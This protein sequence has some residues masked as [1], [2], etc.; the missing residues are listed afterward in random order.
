MKRERVP[1]RTRE[2]HA[3]TQN[4]LSK[5]GF[6]PLTFWLRGDS[7]NHYATV[8]NWLFHVKTWGHSISVRDVTH[9]ILQR[10]KEASGEAATVA[11]LIISDSSW[12]QT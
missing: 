9:R 10:P 7:A 1:T 4:S 2:D 12:G 3:N 11:I 6:V 5:P 8:P